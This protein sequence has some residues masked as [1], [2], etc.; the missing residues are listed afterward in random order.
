MKHKFQILTTRGIMEATVESQSDFRYA[1]FG[2]V[3][4]RATSSC[5]CNDTIINDFWNIIDLV[6][7]ANN[8]TK[9]DFIRAIRV[10]VNNE[11]YGESE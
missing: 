2:Y 3:P 11:I 8:L 7:D 10:Y 6:L 9:D 1:P 4:Y 5:T